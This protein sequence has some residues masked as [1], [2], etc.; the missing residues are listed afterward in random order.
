LVIG[1]TSGLGGLGIALLGRAA[2]VFGL[3][4]VLWS[5]VGVGVVGTALSTML[6]GRR[7]DLESEDAASE[8]RNLAQSPAHR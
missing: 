3:P 8:A 5:L 7:R 1:F 6:P 4:T 2:D